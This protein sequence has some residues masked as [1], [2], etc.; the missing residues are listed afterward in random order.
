VGESNQLMITASVFNHDFTFGPSSSRLDFTHFRFV[1]EH[2]FW[3]CIL[4]VRII[5]NNILKLRFEILT[6]VAMK[7]T[8]LWDVTPCHLVDNIYYYYLF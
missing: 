7:F 5:V 3:F 6:S 2:N 1:S 8:V 4:D